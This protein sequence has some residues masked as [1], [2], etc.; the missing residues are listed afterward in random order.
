MNKNVDLINKTFVNRLYTYTA[1]YSFVF[2]FI[3]YLNILINMS[4]NVLKNNLFELTI[5]VGEIDDS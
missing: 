3:Y 5:S 1:T 2:I 4:V